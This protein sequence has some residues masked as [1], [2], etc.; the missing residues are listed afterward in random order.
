MTARAT[1]NAVPKKATIAKAA[2]AGNRGAIAVKK[3]GARR[4]S[5]SDPQG[6]DFRPLREILKRQPRFALAAVREAAGLRR[7][8]SPRRWARSSRSSL[9]CEVEWRGLGRVDA[10]GVC[11]GARWGGRG[12]HPGS[13]AQV[14]GAVGVGAGLRHGARMLL[15]T[16]TAAQDPA[17]T[18]WKSAPDA[19]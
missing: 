13:G 11:E 18:R 16:R 19:G 3:A 9:A 14:P 8:R 7:S 6:A 15:I 17:S 10:G 5:G 2:L 1:K 4:P 12:D